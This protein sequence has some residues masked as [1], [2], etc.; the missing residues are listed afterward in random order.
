MVD[1]IIWITI[2]QWYDTSPHV[3]PPMPRWCSHLSTSVNKRCHMGL[4]M[5]MTLRLR[6]LIVSR[7]D[8]CCIEY[9]V[10]CKICPYH[11]CPQN[12]QWPWPQHHHTCKS[13]SPPQKMITSSLAIFIMLLFANAC[14][15]NGENFVPQTEH[16]HQLVTQTTLWVLLYYILWLPL[17]KEQIRTKEGWNKLIEVDFPSWHPRMLAEQHHLFLSP[18]KFVTPVITQ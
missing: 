16:M 8:G 15:S 17:E 9:G 1:E 18:S 11:P 5:K 2:S 4:L 7:N 6:L 12:D 13:P 14:K 10:S 3:M